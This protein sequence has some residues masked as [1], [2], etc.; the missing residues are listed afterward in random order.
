MRAFR[1]RLRGVTSWALAA[2]D[3]DALRPLVRD[4]ATS[5]TPER[6][7]FD[8]S[9]L[10]L[11]ADG[12]MFLRVADSAGALVGYVVATSHPTL[13]ADGNV[14]SVEELMARFVGAG[15]RDRATGGA[16]WAATTLRTPMSADVEVRAR[17]IQTHEER[18]TEVRRSA[19]LSTCRHRRP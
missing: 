9:F 16:R 18:P 4:F 10:A 5:F 6:A 17:P 2:G 19:W 15:A 7:T 1:G 12:S 11:R 3:L 8:A 13:F 14:G